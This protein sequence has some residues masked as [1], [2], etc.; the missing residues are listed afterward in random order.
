MALAL[1]A[2]LEVVKGNVE[3]VVTVVLLL[4][5]L[6]VGGRFLIA[7]QGGLE[8]PGKAAKR[9]RQAI[10]EKLS[11]EEAA[12]AEQ[13]ER[14][15][16]L[17]YLGGMGVRPVAHFRVFS[18]RDPFTK[19]ALAPGY[20]APKVFPDL[21]ELPELPEFPEVELPPLPEVKRP[22][23]G[24]IFR[25]TGDLSVQG[26]G[27][28]GM[29]TDVNGYAHWVK[30]GEK[31]GDWG[32]TVKEIR[33]DEGVIILIKGESGEEFSLEK[34]KRGTTGS[35][36]KKVPGPPKDEEP[37]VRKGERDVW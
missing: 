18:A 36:K 4:V 3:K 21:P 10:Q 17:V 31:I 19:I 5:L 34:E 37:D 6:L 33:R 13:K 32:Y 9:E 22:D 1:T 27:L 2:V 7:S 28:I 30:V 15:G 11:E 29:I 8:D 20:E 14:E 12:A 23:V 16:G 35:E 24:D 25:Y 26:Q